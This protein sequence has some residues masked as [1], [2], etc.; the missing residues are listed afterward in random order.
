MGSEMEEFVQELQKQ[1]YEET[2]I[3]YGE[4]VFERW[5]NM[6]YVGTLDHPDGYGI[7][8]G[9]CGDTMEIFLR[10]EGDRVTEARFRTDGCSSTAVCGSFAAEAALGNDPDEI[11]DITGE[12]ILKMLGGLPKEEEHCATLAAEALQEAL[13][14]YM[15]RQTGSRKGQPLGHTTDKE[16]A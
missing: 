3:A 2:K 7:L 8:T 15:I 11:M 9:S 16:I 1:I 13:N 6:R 12:A 14:D 5:R 10:F 4:V